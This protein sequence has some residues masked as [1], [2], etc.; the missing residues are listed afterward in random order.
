MY[1]Y[2][3]LIIFPRNECRLCIPTEWERC[4]HP[5]AFTTVSKTFCVILDRAA[6]RVLLTSRSIESNELK[7]KLKSNHSVWSANWTEIKPKITKIKVT[8]QYLLQQTLQILKTENRT[9]STEESTAC[10]NCAFSCY[11]CDSFT[12]ESHKPPACDNHSST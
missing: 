11:W 6:S 9:Q 12:G 4:F 5:S 7:R 8:K 2:P 10:Y 1:Y 3:K